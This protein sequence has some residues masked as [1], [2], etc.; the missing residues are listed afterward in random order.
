M[1]SYVYRLLY[2]ITVHQKLE[3]IAVS[4]E[5]I[6]SNYGKWKNVSQLATAIYSPGYRRHRYFHPYW[7]WRVAVI[8]NFSL[9]PGSPD[10]IARQY[11]FPIGVL[12]IVASLLALLVGLI[13]YFKTIRLYGERRAV[14]Q[15]G[16]KTQSIAVVLG[17]FIISV[18]LLFIATKATPVGW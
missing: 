11:H 6:C 5:P 12:F 17:C 10:K 14:V 13:N 4:S 3:I 8:I 9:N 7:S 2:S 1:L 18:A 16:F 15:V